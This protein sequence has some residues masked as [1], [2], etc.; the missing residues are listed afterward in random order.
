MIRRSPFDTPLATYRLQLHR[1]FTFAQ[2]TALLPYLARLGISH[3]YCSPFL[4]ARAGSTHGYD[5]VD[6]SRINPE[7]GDDASFARFCSS[8]GENGLGLILDFVPNHMGIGHADNAWWLDVLE[9]GQASPYAGYFDIDWSPP[10]RDLAGK[11]LV[12]I[13][14]KSYGAALTDGEIELRFNAPT[15]TFDFWYAD[16]RLPLSPRD[17]AS[18]LGALA[19]ALPSSRVVDALQDAFLSE[20]APH[21]LREVAIAAKA[22]L[23]AAA[24]DRATR[25]KI[26]KTAAAWH[27]VTG[28]FPSWT[29]FHE[30]LQ[31]QSFRLAHWRTASDEVNYRRFFDI[32]ELAGMR[33]GRIIVFRDTHEFLGRLLADGILQGLR[34]DHVDGLADPQ[35]YCRR[36]NAFAAAIVP[37][38]ASGK[39]LRPYILVEKILTG[40]E[41]LPQSWPISGTTGYDYLALANGLFIEPTGFAKLQRLWGRFTGL[42][43]DVSIEEQIYRCRLLVIDRN[44]ASE[45]TY[46]VNWLADIT[47]ADWFTRD[48]T[49][50]RLRD[51]LT[52]IVAAFSVYRT[53]VTERGASEDDRRV[54]SEAVAKAHRR[55]LGADGEILDFIAALLTLDIRTRSPSHFADKHAA[56]LRFVARFQQYTGAIAA[57][58]VEDTFFYRFVPLASANEVGA[59]PY[60]PTTA[61]NLYHEQMTER[62]AIWPLAMLAS[63]THDT[64]RGEDMR[65]RLDVLS[66]IPDEWARRVARWHMYNRPHRGEAAG[67]ATPSTNDEYLLYQSIVG[68]WPMQPGSL[69]RLDARRDE[70]VA[71][72]KAY[73][74][75]AAREAKLDT[76]WTAPNEAYEAGTEHFIESLFEPAHN[77]FTDNLLRFLPP[78]LRFGA[79]NALSQLVLKATAPGVP[80]FY[81]GAEFWDL[82]LV[83]PD[84]RRP[85]DFAA[86]R[87]VFSSL[88]LA[89]AIARWRDG[90]LKLW[91]TE[92][93][94]A[95]RNRLPGLFA[96]GSYEPLAITGDATQHVIAF[97]RDNGDEAIIVIVTRLLM[98]IIRGELGTFWPGGAALGDTVIACDG[99]WIDH[100]T[101]TRIRS[102]AQTILASAALERLPVAVLRA[103]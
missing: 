23:A 37:R 92:R 13:L 97:R 47:E 63:A 51:A 28:D 1:E 39:R 79:F 52:E 32:P 2:A 54:I 66:E 85:V 22:S 67:R 56:I 9:W 27:G 31:R 25:Q 64:K 60:R 94:L 48:F 74:I 95:L 98:D 87:D 101:G 29:R 89:S 76:S 50:K 36:L 65:A 3:V 75:K 30:L 82:S 53:Y 55:W 61:P 99:V 20:A 44:L 10:R 45:L 5:V 24:H 35:R 80:D 96:T 38:D 21:Y 18:V 8:L 70:Y 11:L 59:S 86:R 7:L 103:E 83:D 34:I 49:R 88:D 12:P 84:N 73:A 62:A 72:L 46:L 15:G 33:M 19:H 90:W 26:E 77:P 58:A 16:H 78:I 81:Q 68:T 91:L 4:K 93:L 42:A 71:R 57:K 17:Y 14:G 100:F 69:L 6:Y 102:E 40:A 41:K 43:G